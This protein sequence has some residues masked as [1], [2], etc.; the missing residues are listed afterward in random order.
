MIYNKYYININYEKFEQVYSILYTQDNRVDLELESE[1][2]F[3]VLK[4][5]RNILLSIV[6]Q[7]LH[8]TKIYTKNSSKTA[9]DYI[10]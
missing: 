3:R 8:L 7:N 9:R 6:D 10:S 2:T 4:C 5:D 1:I